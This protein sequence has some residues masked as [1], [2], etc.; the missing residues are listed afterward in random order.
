MDREMACRLFNLITEGHP[1]G[2]DAEGSI[3]SGNTELGTVLHVLGK[4]THIPRLRL[5]GG[6]TVLRK[7]PNG[8]E[9]QDNHDWAP[10]EAAAF[11]REWADAMDPPQPSQSLNEQV[12]Q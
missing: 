8:V 6:A 12:A 4:P 10:K 9:Y 1:V 2:V 11:L 7:L 5:P 3:V